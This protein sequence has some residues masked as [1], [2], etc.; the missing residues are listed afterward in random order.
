[1]LLPPFLAAAIFR[2]KSKESPTEHIETRS[3]KESKMFGAWDRFE[4]S[5]EEVRMGREM[6]ETRV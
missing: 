2:R 5:K 1:M 3:S 6:E 4:V